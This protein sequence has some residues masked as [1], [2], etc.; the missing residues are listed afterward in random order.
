M[1]ISADGN[2]I[3]LSERTEGANGTISVRTFNGS[4]WVPLGN[5]ITVPG[6][7]I[8]PVAKISGDGQTVIALIG[9]GTNAEVGSFRLE[10]GQLGTHGQ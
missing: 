3:I 10:W 4:N 1:D 8:G 7:Q 6:T 2:R 5:D 9:T